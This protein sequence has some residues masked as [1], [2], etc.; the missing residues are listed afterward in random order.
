MTL[1]TLANDPS[2]RYQTAAA[3]AEDIER[4][5]HHR[6]IQARP[7][8]LSYRLKKFAQR[9]RPMI[10]VS[11]PAGLFLLAIGGYDLDLRP[12]RSRCCR[13]RMRVA[14]WPSSTSPMG[15]PRI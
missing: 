9:N 11:V 13:S 1:K 5:L 8:S 14:R 7:A 4:Y 3:M 6:P 12:S 10:G 2:E 15:S